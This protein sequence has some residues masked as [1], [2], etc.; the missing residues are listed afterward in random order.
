MTNNLKELGNVKDDQKTEV[1]ESRRGRKAKQMK[2]DA[3]IVVEFANF[4]NKMMSKYP[5]SSLAF[6]DSV[7][8]QAQDSSKGLECTFRQDFQ[9][10]TPKVL[11]SSSKRSRRRRKPSQS[12]KK[13]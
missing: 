11:S 10:E 8:Y 1:I 3:A 7:T 2:E 12:N 5:E 9:A 6:G 13:N 4:V